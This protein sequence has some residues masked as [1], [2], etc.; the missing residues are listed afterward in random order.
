[1]SRPSRHQSIVHE[2]TPLVPDHETRGRMR[3]YTTGDL[4]S[5]HNQRI[6]RHRQDSIASIQTWNSEVSVLNS[7]KEFVAHQ[8]PSL[9]TMR[10][11][12]AMLWGI[13]AVVIFSLIFLPRTSLARDYRRLHFS[14]LTRDDTQ[15]LFLFDLHHGLENATQT[16]VNNL[17]IL[18][19]L[20]GDGDGATQYVIDELRSYGLHP[21]RQVYHGW[22]MQHVKSHIELVQNGT[23]SYTP[24]LS[25]T[26]PESLIDVPGYHAYSTSGNVTA[27]YIYANYGSIKDY[28]HLTDMG[29]PLNQTIHIVRT[30]G[31]VSTSHK[32]KHAEEHGALAVITFTDSGFENHNGDI[33]ERSSLLLESRAPGDPTT[34]GYPSLRAARRSS[35]AAYIPSIPAVPMSL[36]AIT[37]ILGELMGS[38][39]FDDTDDSWLHLRPGPSQ[40]VLSVYT[41]YKPVTKPFKNILITIPGLLSDTIILGANRDTLTP[42]NGASTAHS[43]TAILLELSRAFSSLLQR[44]WRP[45]RTIVIASWDG[46]EAGHIGSTEFGEDQKDLK[47]HGIAYIDLSGV[48]GSEFTG[49]THPLLTDVLEKTGMKLDDTPKI[50]P[51]PPVYAASVFQYHLGIPS[52]SIGFTNNGT[53]PEIH[54]N[55]V[56]D[57]PGQLETVDPSHSFHKRL[58]AYAGLLLIELSEHEVLTYATTKYISQITHQFQQLVTSLPTNWLTRTITLRGRDM[59]LPLAL[60]EVFTTFEDLSR[61]CFQFDMRAR[62]LQEQISIDYAWFKFY[63]KL[64]LAFDTKMLGNRARELEKE[65]VFNKGLFG[66]EWMKIVTYAPDSKD[67]GKAEMI[68]MLVEAVENGDVRGFEKGLNILHRKSR[69]LKKKMSF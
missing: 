17:S 4:I 8:W 50:I 43:G 53:T 22:T 29:I 34:V 28:K 62:E 5:Q 63:V 65:F 58:A 46:G 33:I 49:M 38:Y 31:N 47:R 54:R 45:L 30:G 39:D 12:A 7:I 61:V 11:T 26:D 69:V 52:C 37:P 60:Q 41:E 35:P 19:H 14:H 40:S 21:Q 20:S 24:K 27:P 23:I 18:S 13:V 68:P 44:G 42:I 51:R 9:T 59:S 56:F 16:H 57:T 66:R 3:S 48:S 6:Q 36:Q 1:M 25:E 32:V 67:G 55:S 15:R 2:R 64:R 10:M